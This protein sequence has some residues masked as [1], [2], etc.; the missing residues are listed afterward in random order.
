MNKNKYNA[1]NGVYA[2]YPT[3]YDRWMRCH[4]DYQPT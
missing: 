4:C 3:E 1:H 2:Y